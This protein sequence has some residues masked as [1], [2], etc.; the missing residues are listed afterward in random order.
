MSKLKLISLILAV[1]LPLG[2]T[3]RTTAP[4]SG[5]NYPSTVFDGNQGIWIPAGSSGRP[6][7]PDAD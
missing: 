4:Q 6:A 7:L 2:C 1:V 3:T 5:A